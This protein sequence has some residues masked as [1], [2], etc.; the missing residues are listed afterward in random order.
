ML[1]I[2]ELIRTIYIFLE[3]DLEEGLKKILLLR[4]LNSTVKI[5]G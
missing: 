5:R 4:Y 2:T 1:D 3:I